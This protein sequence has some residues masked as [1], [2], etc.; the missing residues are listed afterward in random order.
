MYDDLTKGNLT[1][2][3]FVF[4]MFAIEFQAVQL[5][6]AY[7]VKEYLPWASNCG[8]TTDPGIW[9]T[10]K[11]FWGSAEQCFEHFTNQN[12]FPWSHYG[13]YYDSLYPSRD[14]KRRWWRIPARDL[15][16]RVLPN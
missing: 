15:W 2:S 13:T 5:N 10:E 12:A 7:Y 11:Y 3:E 9:Y 16:R 1:R 8:L 14:A 4:R 6:R